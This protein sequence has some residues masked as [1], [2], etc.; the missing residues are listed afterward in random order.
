MWWLPQNVN[1]RRETGDRTRDL[2]PHLPGRGYFFA[3]RE[4]TM[5]DKARQDGNW[6]NEATAMLWCYLNYDD[7]RIREYIL[8]GAEL[9][10]SDRVRLAQASYLPEPEDEP[11]PEEGEPKN[12]TP[13]GEAPAP[14]APRK[15]KYSES[16]NL[17]S[18]TAT[19]LASSFGEDAKC[20][21]NLETWPEFAAYNLGLEVNFH[22]LADRLL[23]KYVPEYVPSEATLPEYPGADD[24]DG[25]GNGPEG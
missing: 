6:H 22:Q 15:S 18:L 8:Q 11:E 4:C 2:G 12:T 24:D 7:D 16:Q 10:M 14:A 19:R 17:L 23:R 3:G 1:H 20:Y 13:P 9:A 25:N 5:S 21:G